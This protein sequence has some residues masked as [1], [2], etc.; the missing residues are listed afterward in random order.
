MVCGWLSKEDDLTIVQGRFDNDVCGFFY[1]FHT[2]DQPEPLTC[3]QSAPQQVI[4]SSQPDG[5]HVPPHTLADS[6]KGLELNL[7][8][9]DQWLTLCTDAKGVAYSHIQ[10]HALIGVGEL[11]VFDPEKPHLWVGG[12][13][14]CPIH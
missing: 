9:P 10:Q 14:G 3:T 7:T 1:Q 4:E 2:Q 13:N 6:I 12:H 8:L 5:H 11:N